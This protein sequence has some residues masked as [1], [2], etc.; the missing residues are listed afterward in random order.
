MSDFT[1]EEQAWDEIIF[2]EISDESLEAAASA[3]NLGLYTQFAFC[4]LN[5]CP[6]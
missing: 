2:V 6:G 3:A 4:T 5:G 1:K